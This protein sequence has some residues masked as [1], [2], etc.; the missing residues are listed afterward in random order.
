MS[1]PLLLAALST[2]SAFES[3]DQLRFTLVAGGEVEG[4]F[5][6]TDGVSIR[7]TTRN[8]IVEIPVALVESA[9]LNGQPLPLSALD[10]EL[11]QA[12]AVVEQRAQDLALDPAPPVWLVA[13]GSALWPGAGHAMMGDWGSFAGYTAIELVFLGTMSYWLFYRETPGPVLPI[14]ALD[15]IFRAYA[16]GDATRAA[17]RR[18]ASPLPSSPETSLWTDSLGGPSASA[19]AA[20]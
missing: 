14:L 9:W 4:W 12:A 17:R 19:P 18:R 5:L 13:G 1:L 15:V 8:E 7:L 3:T 16:V 6:A 2:A 20:P 10:D 11:S